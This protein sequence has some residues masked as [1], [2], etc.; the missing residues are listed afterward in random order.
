MKGFTTKMGLYGAHSLILCD[1]LSAIQLAKHQIFH[2]R[3]KHIDLRLHWIRNVLFSKKFE[4]EYVD[5]KHNVADML[6][7]S[8][9]GNGFMHCLKILH[10]T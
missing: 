1:N 8:L 7:K 2:E 5:T 10:I 4:V 9:P 6:T 3:S